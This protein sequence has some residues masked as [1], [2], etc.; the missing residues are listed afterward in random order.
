MEEAVSRN[1]SVL[2]T[3]S[4]LFFGAA[5]VLL[6]TWPFIFAWPEPKPDP[7]L[8]LRNTCLRACQRADDVPACS[9]ECIDGWVKARER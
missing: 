8:P 3:I 5:C 9:S 7:T 4:V 6:V 1:A 2:W